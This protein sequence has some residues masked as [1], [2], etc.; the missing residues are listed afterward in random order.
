M[1]RKIV[2]LAL[3]AVM[4]LGAMPAIT[5]RFGAEPAAKITAAAAYENDTLQSYAAQ[6]AALVNK[7]R[8]A[9]GLSALKVSDVMSDAANVRAK[10]IQSVFS[11][12]R[13][14]G[15]SCFTALT[16]AGVKY[17]YAAENIA[18]GQKTPEA[19]MKGWMNSSGHRANIL[20]AKAQYI[21]IGVAYKNGTYYWTQFFA[22]GNNISGETVTTAKPAVTTKTTTKATAKTTTKAVTKAAA[23][24]TTKA[25]KKTT[26]KV[27]T[28]APAKAVTTKKTTAK[29]I[30][31]PVCIGSNCNTGNCNTGN[32]NTGNCNIAGCNSA[33]C[34]ALLNCYGCSD[35]LKSLICSMTASC[36]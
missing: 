16:E 28:K 6:I 4:T 9:N 19:V 13:P 12:T 1:K 30:A 36:K 27:T 35:W 14:D 33:A 29:Q 7:E 20:S 10:E 17:T 11:H 18:Y 8:A 31:L 34:E 22:A 2:S 3:A 25:T 26:A 23:K 21:G 32:C 24:T 15:K 5:Q